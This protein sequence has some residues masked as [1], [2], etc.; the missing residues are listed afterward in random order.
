LVFNKR[1]LS[2]ACQTGHQSL[3]K[4]QKNNLSEYWGFDMHHLAKLMVLN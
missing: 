3:K 2:P 1:A 4:E